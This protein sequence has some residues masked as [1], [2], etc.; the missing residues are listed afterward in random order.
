MKQRESWKQRNY[1]QSFLIFFLKGLFFKKM[2]FNDERGKIQPELLRLQRST[3]KQIAARMD[4][5]YKNLLAE[6]KKSGNPEAL[7]AKI[8]EH[9]LKILAS[10]PVSG[11][12]RKDEV[13][14]LK[15]LTKDMEF[16]KN[17]HKKS[18]NKDLQLHDK[19]CRVMTLETYS[20]GHV[21]F[22]KNDIAEKF[23]LILKGQVSIFTTKPEPLIKEEREK[24]IATDRQL[25]EKLVQLQREWTNQG[26]WI[27]GGRRMT[28]VQD[29]L[30]KSSTF[31]IKGRAGLGMGTSSRQTKGGGGGYTQKM[32]SRK[33][34]TL[35][36]YSSDSSS[37][38]SSEAGSASELVSEEESKDSF[39]EDEKDEDAR[40]IEAMTKEAGLNALNNSLKESLGGLGVED[41]FN[42][43]FW[44][45]DGI[46]KHECLAR[47]KKG[48]I[49][50]ELGLLT[51]HPRAGAAVA[52]D[53]MVYLAVMTKEDY[54]QILE[55]LNKRQIKDKEM[56]FNE[57]LFKESFFLST[58]FNLSYHFVKKS[59]SFGQQIFSEGATP[60]GIYIVYKGTVKL[61][62][63]FELPFFHKKDKK[64]ETET[65]MK[66]QITKIQKFDVTF[67]LKRE[68]K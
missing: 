25:Y 66:K 33:M 64:T 34:F 30:K 14:I 1:I 41:L 40:L 3:D 60:D 52:V 58:R 11:S 12:R 39:S 48:Q 21:I 17:I 15:T 57:F 38:S 10:K 51:N 8:F 59:Y 44:F 65:P 29:F 16:F 67:I 56:F 24:L 22:Q 61:C 45:S 13:E 63:N 32:A 7:E 31:L 47:L 23:Y 46:F 5:V 26:N 35:D 50:G 68:T 9:S 2:L 4:F 37:S 28:A 42:F 43:D 27:A 18:V 49:F 53:D 36:E 62:K 55:D 20:K 19:C 6:I 54:K